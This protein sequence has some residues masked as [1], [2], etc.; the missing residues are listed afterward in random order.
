MGNKHKQVFLGGRGRQRLYSKLLIIKFVGR[1]MPLP[2]RYH[3][4]MYINYWIPI[5]RANHIV[6]GA[7]SAIHVLPDNQYIN[8]NM[9]YVG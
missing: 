7:L 6:I 3:S 5:C 4:V 1:G 2:I 8:Q 9:Q